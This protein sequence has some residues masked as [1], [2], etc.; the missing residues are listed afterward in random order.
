MRI[1]GLE[2]FTFPVP[3]KVVFRHA[4][5]KRDRA[6]NIIAVVRSDCGRVGYGEGCPRRYV[7]GET[8][9]SGID[10][11]RRHMASIIASVDDIHSLG[12]WI[13]AN[14]TAID[15]NPAAFCAVELAVLDLLGKVGDRPIEDVVG[16]PHLSQTYNYSAVLGDAP[17]PAYWWQ[18][19]RY[20]QRGFRDF[21]I[22]LSGEI[23]RD[24]RKI[25]LLRKKNDP[26][27]RVR[28]DANNL[29]RS[30][31][32]CVRHIQGL[33]Y[34][35]FA[36]E[37]PLKKGD[38]VGFAGVGEACRCKIILDES[39]SRPEQLDAL[40]GG[41]RWIVNL[42]ISKMGGI[43]RSLAVARK[44]RQRDIEIIVGAQV[45]ETSLLT[46]AALAVANANRDNLAAAEGA[47]GTYLLRRD[48]T[49]PSLTF[50]GAGRLETGRDV[51]PTAPGLGL[52]VDDSLLSAVEP[53]G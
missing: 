50:R 48:L 1:I 41:T 4:S 39:L 6:E 20:W 43:L 3:F 30:A 10:F 37:E 45:G 7:T 12:K 8:V 25:A 13:E 28:L 15:E 9:A 42:R 35:F 31:D 2:L 5:A 19:R 29:W 36:I 38:L 53:S 17:F 44:A 52:T 11:L 47:F 34:E 46:R 27:L 23:G 24:R 22:K 14:R 18:L 21:K 32:D 16:V 40:P 51:N 49:S 33:P 26:D